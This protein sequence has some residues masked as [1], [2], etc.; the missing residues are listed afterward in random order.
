MPYAQIPANRSHPDC[1]P[2]KQI[3]DR[4]QIRERRQERV[5]PAF[6]SIAAAQRGNTVGI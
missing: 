4:R 1:V 2:R 6:L 5:G 3:R